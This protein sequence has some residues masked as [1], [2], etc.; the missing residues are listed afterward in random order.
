MFDKV[1]KV[2]VVVAVVGVVVG[3]VVGVVVGVGGNCLSLFLS[4]SLVSISEELGLDSVLPNASNSSVGGLVGVVVVVV[5]VVVA[6]VVVVVVVAVVAV[7]VAGGVCDL[8]E[9]PPQVGGSA[10]HVG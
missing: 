10:W 6:V 5:A 1:D 8:Q 3:A 9:G 7:V 4:A 2:L